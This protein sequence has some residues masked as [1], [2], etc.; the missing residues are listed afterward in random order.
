MTSRLSFF[1]ISFLVDLVGMKT[2]QRRWS[3]SI[4]IIASLSLRGAILW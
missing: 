4:V 2:F 3:G 1:I